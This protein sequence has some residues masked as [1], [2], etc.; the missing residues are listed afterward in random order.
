MCGIAGVFSSRLSPRE[1]EAC[2]PDMLQ[3]ITHR[4][5]DA[6]GI[7]SE[8]DLPLALGHR[9]LSILDLSASGAQ[10]MQAAS[11]R[12]VITYNGEIYNHLE[13]R[14]KLAKRGISWKGTS[15]TETLLAAIECFGLD[16]ALKLA[17]G[18]FAFALWDR[19]ERKLSLARD[20]FGEKPLYFYRGNS[21]LVFGSDLAAIERFPGFDRQL[22]PLS[23]HHYFHRGWHSPEHTIWSSVKKVAPGGIVEFDQSFE[24]RPRAYWQSA[25]EI[26]SAYRQLDHLSPDEA[27]DRLDTALT[28]SV[29]RQ[30]ISDV[31]L[32]AWLS[33]GV[34]SSLVVA[35]MQKLSA[36]AMKTFSI[37]FSD[38]D[39]DE[40]AFADA[41]A[42][43]LGTDHTSAILEPRQVTD[44]VP[45]LPAIFSEPFSDASQ[46]PTILLARMTCDS[47]TVALTGDGADEL[48]GG[49]NRHVSANS[50]ARIR[51]RAAGLGRFAL[52][53]A[54]VLPPALLKQLAGMAGQNTLQFE[55]K[56]RKLLGLLNAG[57]ESDLYLAALERHHEKSLLSRRLEAANGAMRLPGALERLDAAHQLMYFDTRL[58]MP[59]D[60][61]VKVDRSAMAASLETRAPFLD[62]DVFRFAWQLPPSQ[63]LQGGQNKRIL[64][65]LLSRYLPDDLF[66][67][68]K[69]GFTPPIGRWLAGPL[70]EWGQSIL[71]RDKLEQSPYLDAAAV[72]TAWTSLLEG[73]GRFADSVWDS[74]VFM[75]WC[76][77]R[78]LAG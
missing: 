4:G 13:L 33:G 29:Q 68:P 61:L 7:W 59:E 15:D 25:A 36:K 26:A 32:G 3:A 22:D 53:G 74:I 71:A 12:Y 30:L 49:Y 28:R 23:I 46:L 62:P 67:R 40:S 34:D 76:D 47:V 8:Q 17:V 6:E 9:R 20:R 19:K 77:S 73:D 69:Q 48:F 78:G 66:D 5:P 70:K 16:A 56:Y 37:G 43:H 63:K 57:N 24:A 14:E 52:K 72:Q 44:L 55:D 64:R 38:S 21:D 42:S 58:Y 41:I 2:L 35:L 1:A 45:G 11:G 39:Y 50:I 51:K 31:P 75:S 54:A 65:Q 27:L 10:P 18:M 60:V